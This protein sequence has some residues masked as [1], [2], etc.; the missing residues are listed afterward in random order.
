[1]A[2]EPPD[3]SGL[4]EEH[5]REDG[6]VLWLKTSKNQTGYENVIKQKR[7]KP[8]SAKFRPDPTKKDQRHLPGSSSYTA[9]GAAIV[10]A[11]HLETL[12]PLQSVKTREHSRGQVRLPSILFY[13]C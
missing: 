12:A 13:C 8:Y 3:E 6:R 2:S 1:M 11:E 9:R 4:W 5:V 7:C 10:L